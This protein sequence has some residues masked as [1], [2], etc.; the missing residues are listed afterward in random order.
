MTAEARFASFSLAV[1]LRRTAWRWLVPT[2][3]LVYYGPLF[4]PGTV[5]STHVIT[6]T[7][8]PLGHLTEAAYSTGESFAYAYDAVGNRTALTETTAEAS[9]RPLAPANTQSLDERGRGG[10]YLGC[11]GEP[12]ERRRV[13]L[14]LQW[15]EPHD[16]RREYHL[17]AGVYVRRGWIARGGERL[18]QASAWQF[19]VACR[20]RTLAQVLATSDDAVD[21]C[22]LQ[23]IGEKRDGAWAYA[24]G[25]LRQWTD[26]GASVGYAAGYT[27][28]GVE[29]WEE[30][31]TASAWG[32]TGEWHDPS[33][34]M[35]Y[36]RA[37]WYDAVRGRFP[38]VD[39]LY[40]DP[41]DPRSLNPYPYATNDP[42]RFVDSTGCFPT[43]E[44][45]IGPEGAEFTCNCGWIDWTHATTDLG[46]DLLDDLKYAAENYY[47]DRDLQDRWGFDVRISLRRSF[48]EFDLFREYAVIP[49]GQLMAGGSA[50]TRLAVSIFMD[51]NE[52]FEKLQGIWGRVP[53]VGA[54][55]R[56]SCFSEEDLVSDIIAFYIGLQRSATGLRRELLEEQVRDMCGSV[57]EVESKKVFR[58]TYASGARAQTSWMNWRP[59]FIPLIGCNS[60]YCSGPRV[61]PSEFSRLTSGRILPGSNSWW[62]YRGQVRDGAA[63]PTE[64][65]RI[66]RLRRAALAPTLPPQ[67]LHP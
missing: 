28:F 22:G 16:R 20:Q 38:S 67:V 25:S 26:D 13:H 57:G 46:Y 40:P 10:V 59:R 18:K 8:D 29:L 52:H 14:H 42:V 34:E 3:A 66:F 64:E 12:D 44:D 27:P 24:L 63:V 51:A 2:H 32:F 19:G 56:S 48:L 41:L 5:T 43:D 7:Y 17:D 4:D 61:W 55:L 60:G 11:T 49:H 50:R 35:V 23:R 21:V 62:W 47:F 54:R 65:P 53:I 15:G 45:E 1:R 39:P 6:Y 37:R 58:E 33:A 30:G 36:L 31:S 9:F